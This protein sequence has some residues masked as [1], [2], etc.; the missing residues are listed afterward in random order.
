V[1]LDQVRTRTLGHVSA[2]VHRDG[3]AF[4]TVYHGAEMRLPREARL[5]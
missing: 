2:G 1:L 5:G 3:R 4:F